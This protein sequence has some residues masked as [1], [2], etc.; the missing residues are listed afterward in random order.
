M[1]EM[2]YIEGLRAHALLVSVQTAAELLDCSVSKVTQLVR[3]GVL[4]C[5][6]LPEGRVRCAGEAGRGGEIEWKDG[7]ARWVRTP[8]PSKGV[9]RIDSTSRGGVMQI[10]V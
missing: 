5:V 2:S 10:A 1:E 8:R 7:R 9:W 6:M 4:P 3:S